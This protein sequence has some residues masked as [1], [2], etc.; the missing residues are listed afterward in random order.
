GS[1]FGD[2]FYSSDELAA[3]FGRHPLGFMIYNVV[4]GLASLLFAEPR[5]GVY[6]LLIAWKAREIHPVVVI[7]IVSSL[8]MTALIAWYA[9]TQIGWR[10]EAWSE[11]TRSFV[12]AAAAMV[13]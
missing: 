11:R 8:I 2:T 13:I 9:L 10:R 1:G 12:G 7:N 4:G 5:Q 6:S 3:R